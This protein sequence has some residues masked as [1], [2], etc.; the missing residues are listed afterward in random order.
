M[1]VLGGVIF[2]C[3]RRDGAPCRGEL[4]THIVARRN[5][6]R[7]LDILFRLAAILSRTPARAFRWTAGAVGGVVATRPAR[8]LALTTTL[9]WVKEI[10]HMHMA[11]HRCTRCAMAIAVA[12][13]RIAGVV[14]VAAGVA[15]GGT[16]EVGDCHICHDG[17]D[18]GDGVGVGGVAVAVAV[19]VGVG[20]CIGGDVGGGGGC[21]EEA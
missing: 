4:D 18:D 7:Q 5:H 15:R 21:K 14:S 10:T 2:I 13:S 11:I 17:V 12:T 8:A 16:V 9:R 19:A 1:A 20:A 3:L 6:V